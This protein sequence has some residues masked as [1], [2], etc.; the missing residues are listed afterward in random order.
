MSQNTIER[1]AKLESISPDVAWERWAPSDAEPWNGARASLLHRRA[2]FGVNSFELQASIDTSPG[3]AIDQLFPAQGDPTDLPGADAKAKAAIESFELDSSTL[4]RSVLAT[5]DVKKL[6]AWWLHRML[7]TPHQLVEKM[8][9][10]WHGHFATGAEKVLDPEL[11]LAQNQLLRRHAMGHFSELVHC[12]AKD[13]AMLI[14]LDSVSNR[15]ARANE[16]FARE[17][18]ELFCLGEGNY[19]EEDV[20]QLAKCFTGWEIRRKQFRFN[21]YQHDSSSKRLFGQENIES[22]EQ[23]IDCVLANASMPRFIVRKLFHFLVSDESSPSDDF[24]APLVTRFVESHFQLTPVVK[25]ILSSR[26]MLSGWSIGRKVRSPLELV[27]G[28][29]RTMQCTS[30]LGILQNRLGDLGQS[31]FFPPNVQGWVGGRSWINSA[32]LAAR[33]N[34]IYELLHQENSRFGGGNLAAYLEKNGL[35]DPMQAVQW[36]EQHFLIEPISDLDREQMAE[37]LSQAKPNER[38][39]FALSWLARMPRIHL[40]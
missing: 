26:L 12:I 32:A 34:L 23:A 14:Y 28:W 22:G 29:M 10:F 35:Q 33:S 21:P 4:A 1:T 13:P 6:A 27:L 15:K 11:M 37:A 17:L 24:L 5:S 18:M 9:L 39:E 38:Y 3:Q 40:S 20:Q 16:N 25:M 8:T 31:L 19:S 30:N 36:F 2:G 7:H